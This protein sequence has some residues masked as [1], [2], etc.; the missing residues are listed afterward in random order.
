[1]FLNQA[2]KNKSH[3]DGHMQKKNG[4]KNC[5]NFLPDLL[6]AGYRNNNGQLGKFG[7]L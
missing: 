3:G 4:A 2:M 7:R 5:Q 1:M 6:N